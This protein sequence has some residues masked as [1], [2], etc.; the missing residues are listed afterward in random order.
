[1][2]PHKLQR[3]IKKTKKGCRRKFLKS[4]NDSLPKY[5]F[6]SHQ[7]SINE[8]LLPFL[9]KTEHFHP[10]ILLVINKRNNFTTKMSFILHKVKLL[11][12]YKTYTDHNLQDRSLWLIF[13]CKVFIVVKASLRIYA[14]SLWKNS[15]NVHKNTFQGEDH[16]NILIL[17]LKFMEEGRW[18]THKPLI[19]EQHPF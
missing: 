18:A 12:Y 16:E 13:T 15:I 1:M 17:F 19:F 11:N 5:S 4:C 7:K 9:H 14:Y 2:I 8:T 10:I 3:N 6:K